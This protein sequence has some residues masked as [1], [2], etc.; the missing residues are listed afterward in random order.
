MAILGQMVPKGAIKGPYAGYM[1]PYDV[2][3]GHRVY[4]LARYSGQ[5]C[6]LGREGHWATRCHII[7][8]IFTL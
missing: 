2:N 6:V 3:V 4:D 5:G 1:E 8:H 7:L